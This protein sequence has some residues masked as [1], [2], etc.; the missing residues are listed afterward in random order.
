MNNL[1]LA[2]SEVLVVVLD[3]TRKCVQTSRAE[4]RGPGRVRP[5]LQCPV[6]RLFG[7]SRYRRGLCVE[8]DR[9]RKIPSLCEKP[10]VCFRLRDRGVVAGLKHRLVWCLVSTT[11]CVLYAQRPSFVL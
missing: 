11:S 10:A 3:S 5:C 9:W 4:P 2:V 1:S 7:S 8:I 6:S